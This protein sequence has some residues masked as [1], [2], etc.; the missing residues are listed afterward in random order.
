MRNLKKFLALVLAMMM[1]LSLMVTVNAKTVADFPDA[2]EVGAE[3]KDALDVLVA[4][5]I[6]SGRDSGLEPNGTFTRAE[7][8]TLLYLV[9]NDDPNRTG[10]LLNLSTRDCFSDIGSSW[11]RKYINYG[12]DWGSYLSG[13]GNG[14]YDPEGTVTIMQVMA[15]M[16]KALNLEFSGWG[17]PVYAAAHKYGLD[18][19]LAASDFEGDATRQAAAQVFYNAMTYTAVNGT[20]YVVK[21]RNGVARTFDTESG[22]IVFYGQENIISDSDPSITGG[23]N[24]TEYVGPQASYKGSLL[25]DVH[26]VTVVTGTEDGFGRPTTEYQKGGATIL[27]IAEAPMAHFDGTM[28]GADAKPY[29]DTVNRSNGDKDFTI[30]YNGTDVTGTI[31]GKMAFE[32]DGTSAANGLWVSDTLSI[33]GYDIYIYA[34]DAG[35]DVIVREAYLAQ[36]TNIAPGKDGDITVTVYEHADLDLV[37]NKTTATKESEQTFTTLTIE[38]TDLIYE[39]ISAYGKGV[40]FAIYLKPNWHNNTSDDT[41]FI[42]TAALWGVEG[43]ITRVDDDGKN[44]NSTITFADGSTKATTY[45]V[46]NEAV[47]YGVKNPDASKTNCVYKLPGFSNKERS[48]DAVHTGDAVLYLLGNSILFIDQSPDAGVKTYTEHHYGYLYDT[49]QYAD[50]EGWTTKLGVQVYRALLYVE[51]QTEPLDTHVAYWTDNNWKADHEY[52]TNQTLTGGAF[53]VNEGGKF[54]EYNYVADGDYY[55]VT[56]AGA[57]AANGAGVTDTGITVKKNVAKG[58][59]DTAVVYDKLTTFYIVTGTPRHEEVTVITGIHNIPSDGYNTVSLGTGSNK[60]SSGKTGTYSYALRTTSNL[61]MTD[62]VKNEVVQAVM[63]RNPSYK[64]GTADDPNAE[65]YFIVGK[66]TATWVEEKI[67]GKTYVYYMYNGVYNGELRTGKNGITVNKLLE[68]SAMQPGDPG[69]SLPSSA[70]LDLFVVALYGDDLNYDATNKSALDISGLTANGGTTKDHHDSEFI[71]IAQLNT[72]DVAKGGV[73][74]FDADTDG[75]IMDDDIVMFY[76]NSKDGTINEIQ[77]KDLKDGMIGYYMK[78]AENTITA[79]FVTDKPEEAYNVEGANETLDSVQAGQ[80]VNVGNGTALTVTGNVSGTINVTGNGNLTVN[81]SVEGTIN[82][83]GTGT[84]TIKGDVKKGAKITTDDLTKVDVD[85]GKYYEAITFKPSTDMTAANFEDTIKAAE[86]GAVVL[87]LANGDSAIT[88]KAGRNTI[89]LVYKQ[90]SASDAGDI[91]LKIFRN[92]VEVDHFPTGSKKAGGWGEATNNHM[93]F[94]SLTE[95]RDGGDSHEIEPNPF[96]PGAYYTFTI[97][98]GSKTLSEGGF[99]V[100]LNARPAAG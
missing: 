68:E 74:I 35:Y 18:A 29:L 36:I 38:S 90:D 3:Y 44:V 96:V 95:P 43:E 100:P 59:L 88:G 75:Y 94:F 10:L 98:Q 89:S 37:A 39:E 55:Q 85:G 97:T 40:P 87:S 65:W 99:T 30:I 91:V 62:E 72:T 76:Y 5:G 34:T 25:A 41:Y 23:R 9:N 58:E 33:P 21:D 80:S 49:Y 79:L 78:S 56:L 52:G 66:P 6:I 71:T 64:E 14:K 1:V 86:P 54:V 53:D 13:V 19:G 82:K 16:M 81:G 60:Y 51:G 15:A 93:F 73:I 45:R 67:D 31:A 22:A 84:L 48:K 83:T 12:A 70:K 57:P 28:T 4:L 63:L 92:G 7:L 61:A 20:E 24:Q 42:E 77:A 46:S 50:R 69:Y 8:A 32:K 2:G 17:V 47:W 11:A 26:K 27:S